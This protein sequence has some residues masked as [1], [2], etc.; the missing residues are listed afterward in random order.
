MF[1]KRVLL[2]LGGSGELG[3]AITKKFNGTRFKKW[4]VFNIDFTENSL[5]NEN[6]ILDEED[7]FHSQKIDK[8][9]T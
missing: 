7:T 4:K 2:L 5:A 8:L 1:S 3:Q 9:H 6:F